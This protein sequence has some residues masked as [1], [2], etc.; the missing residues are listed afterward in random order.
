MS[1]I[2]EWTAR[3]RSGKDRQAKQT[4]RNSVGFCCLGVATDQCI[5]AKKAEGD[6]YDDGGRNEV[7]WTFKFNDRDTKE[8]S[9]LPTTV[10][11]WLGLAHE[12]P[13]FY[14]YFRDEEMT[15]EWDSDSEDYVWQWSDG[16]TRPAQE[17]NRGDKRGNFSAN[18]SLAELNDGGFTFEQIADCIDY[19]FEDGPVER[20]TNATGQV[21]Q[22][23]YT[24][25]EWQ[26][27]K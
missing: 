6:W 12:N 5:A 10:R 4:L 11:D 21:A 19:F 7:L 8:S 14:I 3:L 13:S 16:K 1:I 18:Y 17:F 27:T 2:K 26:A 22:C 15:H 25:L 24:T 20:A 9:T 23:I